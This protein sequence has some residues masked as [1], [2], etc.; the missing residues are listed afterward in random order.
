MNP[1]QLKLAACISFLFFTSLLPAQGP[2]YFEVTYNQA[3]GLESSA[4]EMSSTTIRFKCAMTR[5]PELLHLRLS[6]VYFNIMGDE[7]NLQEMGY[8]TE[9]NYHYVWTGAH[10]QLTER[11][12]ILVDGLAESLTPHLLPL[13]ITPD[14]FRDNRLVILNEGEGIQ[15][16]RETLEFDSIQRTDDLLSARFKIH[17]FSKKLWE[18]SLDQAKASPNSKISE[19]EITVELPDGKV[20]IT[21]EMVKYGKYIFHLK[22]NA[23]EQVIFDRISLP[24]EI[25]PENPAEKMINEFSLTIRR[26]RE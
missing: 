9:L 8:A 17:S 7:I 2:L 23:L 3:Y 6:D 15:Y 24:F 12:T 5:T 26:I 1:I 4:D 22:D 10:F 18:E 21:G 16:D 19:K 13:T 20:V 11:D 25:I 14:M